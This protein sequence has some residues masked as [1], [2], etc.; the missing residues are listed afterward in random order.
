MQI[1]YIVEYKFLISLNF[2]LYKI[3]EK[4][5]DIKLSLLTRP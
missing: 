5:M 1:I 3:I 2:N 4:I